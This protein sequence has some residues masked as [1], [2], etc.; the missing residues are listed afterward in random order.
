MT[1]APIVLTAGGTGGHVFPAVALAAELRRRGRPLVLVTDRRGAGYEE[2][3]P[4]TEIHAVTAGTPSGRGPLG[5]IVA[6]GEIAAGTWAARGLL[7]RIRP[8]AVVGFGG[9]PS[10]PAML[11]A[12]RLGLPTMLHE[13]N[14]VLGRVNRL[15]ASRVAAIATSFAETA[16]IA[17]GERG[18]TSLT[19]NPVR[20]AVAAVRELPYSAPQPG[21]PIRLLVLG[22]SQGARILSEVIPAALIQ[23]PP[24]VRQ[25]IR[26]TQQC[27]P[28]DLERVKTI[29]SDSGVSADLT[30]F[31][32]DVPALLASVHLCITRAGASTVAELALA[33]RPAILVP[34]AAAT[35]DHQTANAKSL[36]AAGGAWLMPEAKFNAASL[37]QTLETLIDDGAAL[38]EMAAAARQSGRP[39]AAG[40]LAD[41]VERLAPADGANP[42]ENSGRAAA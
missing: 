28:E 9:Y 24:N 17:A 26:L 1:G 29:Y 18:K 37:R 34:F 38:V 13:Q 27:R 25:R 14:A 35:D 31:I 22:G 40:A 15:L 7:K 19:G 36:V 32:Q 4:D 41:L 3:F 11:A 23:L 16:G 8:A 6:I 20:E 30:T 33:G 5:R 12:T 42:A 21:G 10:L 2:R 39:N